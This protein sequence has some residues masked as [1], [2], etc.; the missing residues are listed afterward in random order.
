MTLLLLLFKTPPTTFAEWIR[1]LLTLYTDR[2]AFVASPESTLCVIGPG[3]SK[4]RPTPL[5]E[6]MLRVGLGTDE[7]DLWLIMDRSDY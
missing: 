7:V 1:R 5:N 2:N 3:T 4:T 6:P